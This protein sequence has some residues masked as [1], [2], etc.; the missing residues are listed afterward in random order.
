VVKI[1]LHDFGKSTPVLPF[2]SETRLGVIICGFEELCRLLGLQE[3]IVDASRNI[4]L[5]TKK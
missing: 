2:T 1:T 4:I 3:V 5:A